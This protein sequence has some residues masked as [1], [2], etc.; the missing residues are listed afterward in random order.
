MKAKDALDKM[1]GW[2]EAIGRS[3]KTA[4]NTWREV[5]YF[6]H[7]T[8]LTDKSV[9]SI[10][11]Y[12]LNDYLNNPEELGIHHVTSVSTRK[13]KLT[14]IKSF[15]NYCV[16]KG[17]SSSNPASLVKVNIRKVPHSKREPVKKEA[18]TPEEIRYIVANTD[19]FW[20]AAILIALET[21][22][23][24][25][26]IVQLEW[27]CFTP[28]TITVWTDK[29]DMRVELKMSARLRKTIAFLPCE[30]DEYLFPDQRK[31]YLMEVDGGRGVRSWFPVT[32]KRMMTQ[33]GIEGKTFHS[34]RV[35]HASRRKQSGEDI[36]QI[37]KDLAHSSSRTTKK[38]YIT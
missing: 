4:D 3:S 20:R 26:D 2:M 34:L 24:I 11:E 23:R 28:D 37:A 33:F 14:A 6:L 15:L 10:D 13:Y 5:E 32:F 36:E 7:I 38:H 31:D 1:M 22:L 8:K 18:F 21:G 17:W 19:G 35:T 27:D 12:I 9:K 16:A 29:R 25:G 30:D